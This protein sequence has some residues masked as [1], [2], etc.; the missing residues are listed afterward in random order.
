MHPYRVFS[1]ILIT[2]LCIPGFVTADENGSLLPGNTGY[3]SL[4]SIPAGADVY[5]DGIFMGETPATV[6]VATSGTRT[7]TIRI[8]LRGYEPWTITSEENPRAGQ[9][10]IITAM[11]IPAATSADVIVTSS[12]SG[13]I[14]TLDGSQPETTPHTYASIPA[15]TH[16]ISVY[17]SGYQTYYGS[18]DVAEGRSAEVFAQLSPG[19]TSGAIAA[20]SVP[21]GAAIHIDGIY[22]GV[23]PMTVGNLASGQHAITLFKSGY[24]GWQGEVQVQKGVVTTISPALVRDP[25]PVYGT[26]S[27]ASTPAGAEVYADGLYIGET[28]A[29]SP[30]VFREVKPGTHSLLLARMGFQDYTT[31]GVVRAGENYDLLITLVPN[32]Q[33]NNGGITIASSP[34]GAEVFLDNAYRGLSPLSIDDLA[35]GTYHVLI[36]LSG[37]E[38]WQSV[39]NVTPGLQAPLNAIL[40]SLPPQEHRQA[41]ILPYVIIGSLAVALALNLRKR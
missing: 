33:Q 27:I 20:D 3:F 11:L 29:G 34:S 41:G 32:P 4:H 40:T 12:P 28:V 31:T 39:V 8:T 16:Q 36:R 22:R 24:Q 9:T 23:T 35:P 19:I 26:V 38:D 6:P 17:L 5:F 2:I 7:H 14:A 18:V 30:L 37:H 10:I 15:G 21:Q 13:A 1:I 25:Q